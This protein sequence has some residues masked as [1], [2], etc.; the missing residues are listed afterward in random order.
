[1]VIDNRMDRQLLGCYMKLKECHR[2]AIPS[3][4]YSTRM[5]A[6]EKNRTGLITPEDLKKRAEI[7]LSRELMLN[8][9]RNSRN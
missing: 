7:S 5:L 8:L 9:I 4:L 3:E 2:L 6:V 1:M